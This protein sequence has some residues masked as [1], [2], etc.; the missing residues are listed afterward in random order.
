MDYTGVQT[1]LS[2]IGAEQVSK[3]AGLPQRYVWE[4]LITFDLYVDEL[5]AYV[6]DGIVTIQ[7]ARLEHQFFTA[8][9]ALGQ[10]LIDWAKGVSLNHLG[11]AGPLRAFRHSVNDVL[12]TDLETVLEEMASFPDLRSA[13]QQ[14]ASSESSPQ[15][16]GLVH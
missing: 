16:A 2:R 7:T 13:L 6:G 4:G 10:R 11:I 15:P 8:E 12:L 5:V 14:Q 9:L 3:G 1:Y